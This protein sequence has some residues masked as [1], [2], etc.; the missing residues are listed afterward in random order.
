MTE[1]LTQGFTPD[2][3][4]EFQQTV[5]DTAH[6]GANIDLFLEQTDLQT[7]I[8]TR[9]NWLKR[10]SKALVVGSVVVAGALSFSHLN[11]T[12]DAVGHDAKWAGPA[13]VG[14]EI[15][16]WG[17]AGVMLASAGSKLGNPLTVK[18]RLSQIITD[19]E[20]NKVFNTGVSLNVLGAIG[21]SAVIMS[22]A[23]TSMPLSSW[24]LAVEAAGASLALSYLPVVI[25]QNSGNKNESTQG[26][27]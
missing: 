17:G 20:H 21:T 16:A 6:N 2:L 22:G 12:L 24:P 14:T 18:K 7:D 8:I 1:A 3:I 9:E 11:K 23:I 10:H 19:M 13:I 27:K 15:L 4:G 5:L 26:I 25:S